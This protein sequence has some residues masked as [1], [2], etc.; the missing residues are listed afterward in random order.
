MIRPRDCTQLHSRSI[1][2]HPRVSTYKNVVGRRGS[3]SGSG[4][5]NGCGRSHS[6]N[7]SNSRRK[8]K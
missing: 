8:F 4:S 3:G 1:L 2:T 6:S 5:G 7:S